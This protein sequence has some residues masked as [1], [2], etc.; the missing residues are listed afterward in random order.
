MVVEEGRPA[1]SSDGDNL[2]RPDL[3]GPCSYLHLPQCI[4]VS[5]V[6]SASIVT[7]MDRVVFGI[8]TRIL[9]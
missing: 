6:V 4:S 5:G 7:G 2:G 1:Q 8:A 3:G 9:S